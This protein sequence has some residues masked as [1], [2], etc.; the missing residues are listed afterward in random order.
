MARRIPWR[1]TSLV[2]A[3]Y[4]ALTGMRSAVLVA[5]LGRIYRLRSWLHRLNSPVPAIA[6]RMVENVAAGVSPCIPLSERC[7]E[8]WGREIRRRQ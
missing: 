1:E 5:R 8:R 6:R 3:G 7:G 4:A 2:A